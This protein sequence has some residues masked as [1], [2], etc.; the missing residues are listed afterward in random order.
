MC[1]DD[2]AAAAMRCGS[3]GSPEIR[4]EISYLPL[5]G[6]T[7]AHIDEALGL[8]AASGLDYEIGAYRTM[9]RGSMDNIMALLKSLYTAA[10]AHGRF[11]IDVRLSN[12]CGY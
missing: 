6:R 11:V 3:V 8:I 2:K 1:Q 9:L 4:C 5:D 12:T 7:H 10:D